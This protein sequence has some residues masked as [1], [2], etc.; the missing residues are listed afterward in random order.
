MDPQTPKSKPT[1]T[2]PVAVVL[3]AFII[4]IALIVIKMPRTA[5]VQNNPE[6]APN[7]GSLVDNVLATKG[8]IA[9]APIGPADHVRGASD[10]KVTIVEYSDLECP[11]CKNFHATMIE[12]VEKSDDVKWVYRHYPLDCKDTNN[13]ECVPLHPRARAEAIASECAAKQGGDELFW[14]FVDETFTMSPSASRAN[15]VAKNIGLDMTKFASCIADPATAELVSSQSRDAMASGAT[16]T[17]YSVIIAPSGDTYKISG[18]YP[19]DVVKE[20]VEKLTN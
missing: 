2:M 1:L 14:K 16:G 8:K 5:P 13:E 19:Y 7:N 15:T 20:V 12:L 17:P 9:I 11:F 3:S 18:A 4:A 10:A 6:G